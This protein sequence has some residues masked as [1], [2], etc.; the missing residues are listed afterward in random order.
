MKNLAITSLYSGGLITNYY[1]S[2]R[3]RHCLYRCSPDWP[4]DYIQADTAAEN[5]ETMKRL[6]CHSIHIGGGEPMLNKKGLVAV[7]KVAREKGIHIDYVETN[8]SWYSTAGPA[9]DYLGELKELGLST[10]LVSISPFHN[11]HIPFY[12]VKGVVSACE[13]VG[14]SVFPWIWDFYSELESMDEK[15]KHPPEEF[16]KRFGPNYWNSVLHRYWISPGG[17]ALDFLRQK[18]PLFQVEEI[19]ERNGSGCSELRDTSHFHIDLYGN[20]VPGLC[21]GFAI[22]QN[23]LGKPLAEDK[24]PLLTLLFNEGISGLL[25]M[26]VRDF[27]FDPAGG[28]FAN[29]CDL[30][31]HIRK[32]MI[33]IR[34]YTSIELQPEFHYREPGSEE[35]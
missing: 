24:Y 30:C 9:R 20:Y 27:Q 23:D 32:H 4:K 26:A 22:R 13:Q 29:K 21:A 18:G 34:G 8:S 3:C 19:L 6:G 15:S 2:S 1:C 33:V 14:M 7:L 5:F 11:E 28:R 10:L 31:Y 16:E 35:G 17:R 12:K 25:N